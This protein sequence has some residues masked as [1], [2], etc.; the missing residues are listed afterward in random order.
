M[1]QL[2]PSTNLILAVLAGLGVLASLTMPWYA[3]PAEDPTDTDGPIEQGAFQVGQVFATSA[4]GVVSGND[5]IGP[6][7]R[8]ALLVVV[9]VVAL[10]GVAISAN[11]ARRH[12]EDMLRVAAFATPVVVLAVAILHPGT[13]AEVRLHYGMLVGIAASLFSANAAFHGASWREKRAAP[14]RPR[15]GSAR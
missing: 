11:V 7:G 15:F 10:L 6:N 2:N 14:V 5:A 3:A 8:L 13:Q 4:K 9:A 12:A 1:R